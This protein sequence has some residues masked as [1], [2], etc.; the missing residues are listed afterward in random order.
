MLPV[1][2]TLLLVWTGLKASAVSYCASYD[3]GDACRTGSVGTTPGND[4][5]A[6]RMVPK[7]PLHFGPDSRFPGRLNY[8]LRKLSELPHQLL[9]SGM[10][11]ELKSNVIITQISIMA[12]SYS[13]V[14]VGI[15]LRFRRVTGMAEKN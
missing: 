2:S 5:A 6:D 15:C 11:N 12:G 3:D 10:I 1:A 7:Q 14:E 9:K 13:V 4:E 8:N